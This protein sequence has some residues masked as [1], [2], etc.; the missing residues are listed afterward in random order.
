[1]QPSCPKCGKTFGKLALP[2]EQMYARCG[3]GVKCEYAPDSAAPVA[4]LKPAIKRRKP[5]VTPV[6]KR[7]PTKGKK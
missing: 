4:A 5:P 2:A 7:T 3:L 1:M 6:R